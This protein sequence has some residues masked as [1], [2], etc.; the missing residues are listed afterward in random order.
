MRI[1]SVAADDDRSGG[2]DLVELLDRATVP[3]SWVTE[4]TSLREFLARFD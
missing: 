4:S 2:G 1:G 3:E